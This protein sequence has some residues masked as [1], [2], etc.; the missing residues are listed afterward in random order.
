MTGTLAF[1]EVA[2]GTLLAGSYDEMV[3]RT[4]STPSEPGHPEL[5]RNPVEDRDD[6]HRALTINRLSRS[7]L[8]TSRCHTSR[9]RPTRCRP[10]QHGF[11]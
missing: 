8:S 10:T 9:R 4:A 11:G 1:V 3:R 2:L 6:L 7:P 5:A